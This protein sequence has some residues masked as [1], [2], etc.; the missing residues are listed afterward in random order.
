MP[1]A[2][3]ATATI[4]PSRSITAR[5]RLDQGIVQRIQEHERPT[6]ARC[7]RRIEKCGGDRGIKGNGQLTFRLPPV[8]QPD[9]LRAPVAHRRANR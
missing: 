2:S 4:T 8:R 1:D 6:Y 9:Y 3:E 7:F 5:Q